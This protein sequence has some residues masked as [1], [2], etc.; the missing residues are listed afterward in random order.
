MEEHHHLSENE[1]LLLSFLILLKVIQE[2]GNLQFMIPDSHEA[3]L[4]G[5]DGTRE[6]VGYDGLWLLVLPGSQ[7]HISQVDNNQF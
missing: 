2:E 7:Y 4:V 3:S 6:H 1:R 5:G